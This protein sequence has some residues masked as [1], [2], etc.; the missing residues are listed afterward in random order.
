MN[1]P[2]PGMDPY[3]ERFWGDVHASL[4]S[5][6]RNQLYDRLPGDMTARVEQSL[7]IDVDGGD[8][9]PGERFRATH[10]PDVQLTERAEYDEPLQ[11]AVGATATMVPLRVKVPQAKGRTLRIRTDAGELVTTIEF[12]SPGNRGS[13]ASKQQFRAR[14]QYLL[15]AGVNLVEVLLLRGR[16]FPLSMMADEIPECHAED[17]KVA[18]VRGASPLEA[19]F[20]PISIRLP[21]P[22]IPIPLRKHEAETFLELQPLIDLA[23]KYG[24]YGKTDYTPPP[25]V[26][27]GPDA[28]WADEVLK[29]RR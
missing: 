2:F 22:T 23:Y 25:P 11:A 19:D 6:S 27:L 29:A 20:Y 28:Q 7:Q 10:V 21:L 1:S 12:L 5:S 8:D 13:L 26:S 9:E 15:A 4:I 3:L 18:I 14:Q 17:Y 16:G 24:N